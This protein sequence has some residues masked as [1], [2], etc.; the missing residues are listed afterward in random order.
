M[1]PALLTSTDARKSA[2]GARAVR[3]PPAAHSTLSCVVLG[4]R[5]G[6]P[7][8]E[9]AL[10]AAERLF[11]HVMSHAT[12]MCPGLPSVPAARGSAAAAA[13]AASRSRLLWHAVSRAVRR[14]GR[15]ERTATTAHLHAAR[16]HLSTATCAPSRARASHTA[17]PM[18]RAPPDTTA[19][20]P[21]MINGAIGRDEQ[22]VTRKYR[23]YR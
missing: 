8:T 22:A 15:N 9:S 11:A 21:S 2:A 12:P 6:V 10:R 14:L 13:R 16:T 19:R 20:F 3:L 5:C 18:P 23:Q 17:R 4:R 1:A 7:A